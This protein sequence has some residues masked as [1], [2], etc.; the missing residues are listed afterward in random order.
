[1]LLARALD[2]GED[3][4]MRPLIGV[5]CYGERARWG[6]WDIDAVVLHQ[7]YVEA[8]EDSG[9]AVVVVPPVTDEP[10][11]DA[12]VARLDGLVL[13]GGADVDPAAYGHDAHETTDR[14]RL[15]RDRT[16]R[17]LY[18]VARDNGLPVLG[19]CR[20]MQVMAVER[21]GT[22][23]QDLP[24]A[25]YGL[26]HREAPGT[27]TEHGATFLADSLVSRILGTTTATVNS[28]HHQAVADPGSLRVTGHAADGTIEVLEDP[29]AAFVLGV[30][31]HP[32]MTDDRRL[33]AALVAAA[34][35]TTHA[36]A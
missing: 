15:D 13:A 16:E 27:F 5:T 34:R 35:R 10:S 19:I 30:Q 23:I 17:R 20:G 21:G 24:S 25:G 6:A 22:L 1:V 29:D 9:A 32:E 4:G 14:P 11:L 12:V 18:R 31:W 8:L 28:S 2:V 7:A 36:H 26:A 3:G 33:F